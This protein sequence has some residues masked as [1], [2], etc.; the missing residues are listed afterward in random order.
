MRTVERWALVA[1]LTGVALCCGLDRILKYVDGL[2][3]LPS[4]L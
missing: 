2:D 1:A 3:E 4:D